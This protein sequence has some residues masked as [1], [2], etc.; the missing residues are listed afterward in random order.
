MY[1]LGALVFVLWSALV[2]AYVIV[3]AVNP[4]GTPGYVRPT[5]LWA[6]C[7]VYGLNA[8]AA[9]LLLWKSR[10]AGTTESRGDLHRRALEAFARGSDRECERLLDGLGS[11]EALDADCLF[12]RAQAALRQGK[13]RRAKRL[14]RKCRDFDEKGKWSWE[15][16][17]ALEKL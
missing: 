13:R 10:R 6:A 11:M 2:E 1:L 15:I 8:L 3:G 9:L 17:A 7:G 14:F 4:V 5:L 12:L 16:A